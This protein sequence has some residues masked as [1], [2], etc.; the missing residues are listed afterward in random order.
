MQKVQ[1]RNE[2]VHGEMV[3]DEIVDDEASDGCRKRECHLE[4]GRRMDIW[5]ARGRVQRWCEFLDRR[6]G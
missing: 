5:T 6:T 1:R 4:F 2:I 3:A